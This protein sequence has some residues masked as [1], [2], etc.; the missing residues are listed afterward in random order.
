MRLGI[1][2]SSEHL[3]IF[4]SIAKR[5]VDL[6]Q[7]SS[8]RG[9]NAPVCSHTTTSIT[10]PSCLHAAN[11]GTI[12]GNGHEKNLCC[13]AASFFLFPLVFLD[14]STLSSARDQRKK[15]WENK[16]NRKCLHS[17][18]PG[19]LMHPNLAEMSGLCHQA[20]NQTYLNQVLA[21]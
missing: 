15:T 19:W 9:A 14:Q 16:N 20:L 11:T 10:A 17:Y 5:K 6:S 12:Q 2:R 1:A 21:T 7:H 8:R 18:F 3:S 4:F 13:S